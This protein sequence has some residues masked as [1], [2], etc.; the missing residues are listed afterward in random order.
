MTKTQRS[1]K[2]AWHEVY[3]LYEKAAPPSRKKSVLAICDYKPTQE[4]SPT[5]QFTHQYLLACCRRIWVL[6]PHSGS[7]MGILAAERYYEGKLDW[8]QVCRIDW[9]SEG[10]AFSFDYRKGDDDP[11]IAKYV[12]RIRFNIQA[13]EQTL[14][15]P[16]TIEPSEIPALLQRT[17]YF[18]NTA[19]MFPSIKM[20]DK[21]ARQRFE[22]DGDLMPLELFETMQNQWTIDT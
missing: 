20:S 8:K 18:A 4:S 13:A 7:R 5:I 11:A 21:Y 10:T 17:A 19:L 16:R 9:Y 22:R 12:D 15:P 1:K 14:V 3:K 2:S 6:L